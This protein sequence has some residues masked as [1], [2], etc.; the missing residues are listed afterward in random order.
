MKQLLTLAAAALV[1]FGA[2][3]QVDRMA[4]GAMKAKPRTAVGRADTSVKLDPSLRANVGSLQLA[5]GAKQEPA[6]G[7]WGSWSVFVNDAQFQCPTI[8]QIYSGADPVYDNVTVE[9]REDTS[10]SN[11]CEYRI[12]KIWGMERDGN[13]LL[14]L[15]WQS[16][17][18]DG[19]DYLSVAPV[20]TNLSFGKNIECWMA[21]H[22]SWVKYVMDHGNRFGFT[23][24]DYE[25]A[26]KDSYFD[27][28]Q[29]RFRIYMMYFINGSG[30]GDDLYR[31]AAAGYETIKLTSPDYKTYDAQI[32]M[33]WFHKVDGNAVLEVKVN[34]FDCKFAMMNAVLGEPQT[35]DDLNA[36]LQSLSQGQGTKVEQDGFVQLPLNKLQ[37]GK[38]Y[39]VYVMWYDENGNPLGREQDGKFY[40]DSFNYYTFQY[41]APEP[42]WQ[43]IGVGEYTDA[44]VNALINLGALTS[45]WQN[46][47]TTNALMLENEDTPGYYRVEA[48][49]EAMAAKMAA[50]SNFTYDKSS[51]YMVINATNPD[52]VYIEQ[53]STGITAELQIDEAGNTYK[54][55]ILFSSEGYEGEVNGFA[56][57]PAMYGTLKDGVITFPMP[58]QGAD[59]FPLYM[60]WDNTYGANGAGTFK[61]V[62][63]GFT[64]VNNVSVDENA[65]VVYYNLQGVRVANPQNGVYVRVQGQKATKVAL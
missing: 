50:Y 39:T 21:D 46:G 40:V 19:T 6:I 32:S 52:Q 37:N 34:I 33:P 41:D 62:L 23:D 17:S 25:A 36:A 49:Y 15:V 29:G 1:A 48:P 61:V 38:K 16:Q 35:N 20:Y 44:F 47:Y 43:S 63:P 64:G 10:D 53:G 4:E 31:Y 42:G 28:I 12:E 55:E 58:V 57:D 13:S 14:D 27:E 11:L 9:R 51:D 56:V 45:S 5:P 22:G 7:A 54:G 59:A 65:P 8:S 24:E 3:A 2:N 60:I 30:A 26:R 18:E